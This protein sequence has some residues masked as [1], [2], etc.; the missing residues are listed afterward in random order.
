MS[1]LTQPDV[2]ILLRNI[3]A[4]DELLAIPR[5]QNMLAAYPRWAVLEA[6]R[7]VLADRRQRVLRGGVTRE[8]AETLLAPDAIAAAVA[9]AA[10]QK[11][12]PSFI[13]VINATGVILHTNL[14][15]APLAPA[16]LEAIQAT[17]AGYANLEFDLATGTRGSRQVHVE[18]LLCALTGAEAALVVNNNAAAVLLTINTFASGREIVVSRGQ[19]VEIGDSFRIPDVMV[20]ASG[21]LREVGTTNRTYLRDYEGAVG[22]ETAVLLQVHR[23]NFQILGFTADVELSELVALARRHNLLVMDDL[24]SGALLDL[25]LLGLRKEPLAADAIRAG[26][27]LVTF[28]GDKLL[29]GPQ[30]GILVGRRDLLARARKNPLARTVRI[31]KLSLAALE[32]TLRL[33]REPERALREIPILRM[34]GL[35]AAA[36]GARADQAACALRSASSDVTIAIEDE[37]SE[38]GGGALPLQ[39]IPTRVLALRPARGSAAQL[40]ARLRRGRPPVLVR[41]KGDRVLVDLRTV[42]TADEAALLQAL[43]EALGAHAG[44]SA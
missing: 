19:L 23:S 38:V 32:A 17:A 5:I 15:R 18:A 9:E 10:T 35:T 40:E 14:G 21:R 27:D 41:I 30:A 12:G 33:Y 16:A 36:I 39:A 20:R 6:V 25:S 31:D 29:G 1:E 13:P 4:V 26:V 28:S 37:T 44:G 42:E 22:P 3:P 24:G 2:G 8:A 43:R 7:Q 34:L 11:A